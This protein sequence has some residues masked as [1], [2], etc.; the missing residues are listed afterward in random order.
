MTE[1]PPALE[2]ALVE[3]QKAAVA[4]TGATVDF[5]M[6]KISTTTMGREDL[7]IDSNLPKTS[8]TMGLVLEG[9][10][11]VKDAPTWLYAHLTHKYAH[12]VKWLAIFDPKQGGAV[13]VASHDKEI[14]ESDLLEID[15]PE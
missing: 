9:R 4:R 14:I 1:R 12:L 13:V 11:D 7:P 5:E 2:L 3:G 15:R 8:G 10:A 6:L